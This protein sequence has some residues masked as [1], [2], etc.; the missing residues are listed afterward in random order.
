MMEVVHRKYGNS[1][2]VALPPAVL[3]DLGLEAGQSMTLMSTPD[4]KITL[5]D[6]LSRRDEQARPAAM[7]VE[8]LVRTCDAGAGLAGAPDS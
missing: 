5:A 7:A 2:V 4:D 3:K 8:F 6:G 1:T